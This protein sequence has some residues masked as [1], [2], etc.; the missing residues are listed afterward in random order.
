LLYRL[1]VV[2]EQLELNRV[3]LLSIRGR[4]LSPAFRRLVRMQRGLYPAVQLGVH[5]RR[6]RFEQLLTHRK[7]PADFQFSA[8]WA[9]KVPS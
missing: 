8:R 6:L 7:M 3:E 2:V 9:G 5:G 4:N 1:A